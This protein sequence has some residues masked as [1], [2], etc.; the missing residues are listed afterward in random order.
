MVCR[1][2]TTHKSRAVGPLELVTE[3]ERQLFAYGEGLCF[4]LLEATAVISDLPHQSTRS[5]RR[6]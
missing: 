3:D 1:D 2:A 6:C 4:C 5:A